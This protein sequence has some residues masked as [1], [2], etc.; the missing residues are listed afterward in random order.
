VDAAV[1]RRDRARPA[2]LERGPGQ[3][4]YHRLV[5]AAWLLRSAALAQFFGLAV[6]LLIAVAFAFAVAVAVALFFAVAVALALALVV[7][8]ALKFSVAQRVLHTAGLWSA[9]VGQHHG[10]GAYQRVWRAAVSS[11]PH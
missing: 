6:V 11:H 10:P 4:R 2:V 3:Q 9:G 7:V 1:D 8:D 5:S